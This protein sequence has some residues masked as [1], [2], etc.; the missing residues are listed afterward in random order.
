MI[1]IGK[2]SRM[3][4]RHTHTHTHT[5][6]HCRQTCRQ[7][8]RQ[9][10]KKD[11]HTHTHTHTERWPRTQRCD[12]HVK[13]CLQMKGCR[14]THTH[15]H[16]LLHC[17]QSHHAHPCVGHESFIYVTWMIH[18]HMMR[19]M[20]ITHIY[21]YKCVYICMNLHTHMHMYIYVHM[22]IMCMMR[23]MLIERNTPPRG[24]FLFAM[25][26]DQE[27]CVRDFTTRCDGRISSWKRLHL[28]VKSLTYGSWSG[29][30]ANR[31]TPRG[32]G[33][34]SI[35]VHHKS[36]TP[37]CKPALYKRIRQ[38]WEAEKAMVVKRG[39]VCYGPCASISQAQHVQEAQDTPQVMAKATSQTSHDFHQMYQKNSEKPK[40]RNQNEVPI[41]N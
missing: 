40:T 27:P 5:L 38:R 14:H 28:V 15:T 30:I 21:R 24:G 16:T 33:V 8:D 10:I 17:R 29:N 7:A 11:I 31:K 9:T 22:Y 20:R 3:R 36:P 35:N 6:L 19:I 37:C 32:E 25:F 39:T 2:D 18:V 4:C 26:P 34:L 41:G 12:T 13:G 23:I 1:K